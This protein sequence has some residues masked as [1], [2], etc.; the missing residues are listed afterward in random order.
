MKKKTRF[1]RLVAGLTALLLVLTPMPFSD[2]GILGGIGMTA[3]AE[4]VGSADVPNDS[5][6]GGEDSGNGSEDGDSPDGGDENGS[7]SGDTTDGGDE[8]GSDDGEQTD[9]DENG[10]TDEDD[11]SDDEEIFEA[12]INDDTGIL[13]D[14]DE[15][16]S[17][18]VDRVFY[19]ETG[20]ASFA[21]PNYGYKSLTDD[22][23][24]EIYSAL[25]PIFAQIANGSRA[26]TAVKVNTINKWVYSQASFKKIHV[27]LLTDLPYDLYWYNKTAG[28]HLSYNSTYTSFTFSFTPASAYAGSGEY[29]VNTAKTKAA[30]QS[31]A[32]AAGIVA[33]YAGESDYEKLVAYRDELCRMVEYNHAAVD[34]NYA[35][36]DPWQLIYAFDNDPKTNIVC[37]GY[38]KAYQYLCDLST[39]KNSSINCAIVTGD[40]DGG[41]HMWNIVSIDGVSYLADI[42]NTDAGDHSNGYL[43]LNGVTSPS[44]SGF[45]AKYYSGSIKYTYDSNT[46][47]E[48]SSKFLTLS[49]TDYKSTDI[50]YDINLNNNALYLKVNDK[51][52]DGKNVTVNIDDKV[53]ICIKNKD[54]IDHEIT[55]SIEGSDEA[56]FYINDSYFY[57]YY[58]EEL[59]PSVTDSSESVTLNVD[60]TEKAWDKDLLSNFTKLV[61]DDGITMYPIASSGKADRTIAM[62]NGDYVYDSFGALI[63]AERSMLS[64]GSYISINGIKYEAKLVSGEYQ[65]T[66]NPC[67][68]DENGEYVVRISQGGYEYKCLNNGIFASVGNTAL[69]DGDIVDSGSTISFEIRNRYYLNRQFVINGETVTP[70]LNEDYLTFFGYEYTVGDSD[71]TAELVDEN[72]SEAELAK[73][74][75]L[76]F[77]SDISADS[78]INDNAA[79]WLES[80]DYYPR[81]AYIQIFADAQKVESGKKLLVNGNA[82]SL[83]AVGDED[84][85]YYTYICQVDPQGDTLTIEFEAAVTLLIE[86]E[87]MSVRQNFDSIDD[88]FKYFSNGS[89]SGTDVTLIINNDMTISKLTIPTKIRSFTLKNKGNSKVDFNMSSLA[90]PVDTTLSIAGDGENLKPITIS[91]AAGKTLDYDVFP[92]YGSVTVKGT[93]TSVLN[94]NGFLT[95]SGISTFGEVNVADGVAVSVEG[96]VTAVTHFN[97]ALWLKD[98]KYSAAITN[99]GKGTVRL[100][101]FDGKNAK[102]TVSDIDEDGELKV[103]LVDPNTTDEITVNSGRTILYAGSSKNFTDRIIVVNKNASGQALNAY[104]YGK[105]IRAEYGGAVSLSAN[106]GK[107]KF[108]PNL[109]LAIA[110][111]KEAASYTITLYDNIKVSKLTLP[112]T[113][114]DITFNGAD[115]NTVLSLDLTTLNIP[116]STTFNVNAA[117]VNAKP[118]AV[119]AAAKASLEINGSFDNLGA[120]RGTATSTLTVGGNITAASL[121]TFKA[122]N[123]G[124]ITVTGNV[125]GITSFSGELVLPN[126][127]STA[128]IT[129]A[130]RMY[131]DLTEDTNGAIAKVTVTNVSTDNAVLDNPG[132]LIRILDN[133]SGS[134]VQL[135]GGRTVLWTAGKNDFT[136]NVRIENISTT[137]NELSPFLY[138]RE[139]KA[140]YA[141]AIKID[142]GS[143]EKYYPNID[144]AF[145]AINNASKNYT[146]Y[147]NE[148]VAVSKLVFP[149]TAG[150]ITFTGSGSFELNMTAL[151]IPVDTDFHVVLRGTNAKPLAITAA[152]GKTIAFSNDVDNIGAVKGTKTSALYVN[153]NITVDSIAT[154]GDVVAIGSD[155]NAVLSVKGNVSGVTAFSGTLALSNVKS[156]A[157]ITNADGAVLKLADVNGTSPKVTVSDVVGDAALKVVFVDEN[158]KEIKLGAGK[159]VL[160]QGGKTDISDKIELVNKAAFGNDIE[161]NVYGKEV[162][163]DCGNAVTVTCG[164]ESESFVSLDAA[165]A[166]INKQ[167]T[168]ADYI[169]SINE[170]VSASKLTFPKKANSITFSGKG[171]INLNMTALSIPVNTVFGVC[172][173]GTNAKPLAITVAAGKTL[174]FEKGAAVSNIGAVRGGKNSVFESN[175]D[176][177]VGGISSFA[178]VIT[179]ASI[180]VTGNVSNVSCFSGTLK[181]VLPKLTVTGIGFEGG[182]DIILTQT[183]GVIPKV[184]IADIFDNEPVSVMIVD[185]EDTALNVPSGMTVLSSNAKYDISEYIKI[186][187]PSAAGSDTL[188][189]KLVGK[190]IKAVNENAVTLATNAG[191]VG[192]FATIEEAFAKINNANTA[193]TITLNDDVYAAKFT[194]PTKA[195]S[196]T[197]KGHDKT[198]YINNVTAVTSNN[199]LT[200]ENVTIKN[201][202]TFT[203]TAKKNLTL[204]NVTSDCIS[205]VKGTAKFAYSGAYNNLTFTGKNGTEQTPITG[206]G[207]IS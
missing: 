26:S 127:K 101:D 198:I 147:L 107:E 164:G 111:M 207:K 63:T 126:S 151:T 12:W 188:T 135:T 205:A 77:G 117:G 13:P 131:L 2:I 11:D 36:G 64:G 41:A 17:E 98:T 113:A 145:K 192:S 115:K 35:Y 125:S 160:W 114:T 148:D 112:R 54:L 73:Y 55:Y 203:L 162:R 42:T 122:V 59:S 53:E 57:N 110:D 29:T 109:D 157:V 189:A 88:A 74:V 146:V 91:V 139:I 19:G 30:S 40:M 34:N 15:L 177:T 194:L 144:S 183:N 174:T 154:F 161:L 7:D 156:T 48:Y 60:L 199:D 186:A 49:K 84:S 158:G 80:G 116:V 18:Y 204:V 206:F 9:D 190:E 14:S 66:E 3:S 136:E 58:S 94:I 173:N 72:W 108:Y 37:E 138:G 6:D 27:A 51:A 123:G 8:N 20:L 202:K 69:A 104:L 191:T 97:G 179:S 67:R 142:D 166:A 180:T 165:F 149:K 33:Q 83:T 152:A 70:K 16:F 170:I 182:S 106:G 39:F 132:I 96:N 4:E 140:E 85:I 10:D 172:V 159:T 137:N 75:Y 89:Y 43:F 90:V 46:R 163:A 62:T 129:T 187:N 176:V 47:N 99:F 44:G 201:T 171:S 124:T 25:K 195:A 28:V 130:D 118:V 178:N 181:A 103:E 45:S 141:K 38:S 119:T 1:D 76:E 79:G 78:Y 82:V 93:K 169:I 200:I 86:D 196:L 167:N 128:A 197:I 153:T 92:H 23:E 81:G 120:L 134:L 50:S 56:D 168:A 105:E 65:I 24:R 185:E 71:I 21:N 143:E 87:D 102:V 133:E 184:T 68:S 32:N 5:P 31:A 22:G 150:S 95:L 121:A 52:V 193:Y 155:S 61:L 100:Y 175:V